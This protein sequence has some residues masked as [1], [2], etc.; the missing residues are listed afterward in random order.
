V[1]GTTTAP[2]PP[3]AGRRFRLEELLAAGRA[4]LPAALALADEAQR[5]TFAAAEEAADRVAGSFARAG[6]GAGS[7]VAVAGPNSVDEVVAFFAAWKLGA[8][9]APL[10]HRL[11]VAEV[12]RRLELIRPVLVADRGELRPCTEPRRLPCTGGAD[13]PAA[14]L[15]TSGTTGE[16]RA[17]VLS[18][19]GIA[20]NTLGT[21]P[22]LE[23]RPG[24]RFLVATPLC[25]IGGVIRLA[26]ALWSGA[27]AV[28]RARWDVERFARDVADERVTHTMLIGPMLS[29]VLE[30]EA[31]L[32]TLRVVYYGAGR[33]PTEL[34][35]RLAERRPR[36]GWAQGWGQTELS[37]GVTLLGLDDHRRGFAG[38]PELLE[39]VGAP[40]PGVRLLLDGDR[41]EPGEIAVAAEG[42]MLG[43]LAA[44]GLVPPTLRDGALASGDLGWLDEA[45]RLH[46]AGRTDDVIKSGGLKVA[47]AEVE[48]AL[49]CHPAVREAAVVGVDDA[50]YGQAVAAFVVPRAGAELDPDDLRAWLRERL[51]GFKVPRRITLLDVLPRNANGK[52]DRARL[53]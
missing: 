4:R 24:D 14:V 42:L 29:D 28:L 7:V 37:G 16:P 10:D 35:R 53:P 27:A 21:A 34:I 33:T 8:A 40:L 12:E 23:L 32:E 9:V 26:N 30:L 47:P 5:L 15:L 41:D 19:R 13:D 1:P 22:R 39:S 45:G 18:H 51:A 3:L 49:H 11:D 36:L 20:R 2:P 52:I 43:H 48:Q 50:R 25:H 17:I 31:P 38:D 46:V 6:V 44:D